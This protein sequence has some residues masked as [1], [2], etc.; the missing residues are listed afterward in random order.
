MPRRTTR[1][2]SRS[3]RRPPLPEA[4]AELLHVLDWELRAVGQVLAE[5]CR[6]A[7]ELDAAPDPLPRDAVHD[8]RRRADALN[9]LLRELVEDVSAADP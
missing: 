3:R 6:R 1:S 8:L 9:E 7:A 4:R 2:R 5:L